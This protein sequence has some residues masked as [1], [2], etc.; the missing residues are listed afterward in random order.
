MI[1]I[2][3]RR[4][5]GLWAFWSEGQGQTLQCGSKH[6]AQGDYLCPWEIQV[7]GTSLLNPR[8]TVFP[9]L[10]NLAPLG[11][12]STI[13]LLSPFV[14]LVAPREP[15][16]Q[17][18]SQIRPYKPLCERDV[19]LDLPLCDLGLNQ[20]WM[21]PLLHLPFPTQLPLSPS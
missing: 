21:F 11:L 18:S 4:S 19:G 5:P 1:G 9:S 14:P 7:Q 15:G 6:M 3:G 13:P 2:Q 16:K 17:Q 10:G 12:F 8:S 20:L